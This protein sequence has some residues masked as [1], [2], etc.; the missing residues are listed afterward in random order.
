MRFPRGMGHLISMAD[1]RRDR[2]QS[3]YYFSRGQLVILAFGFT[4]TCSIIFFLGMLVGQGIE[5]RKLQRGGDQKPIP[6]IPL[7]A[8]SQ[9]G[10]AATGPS[11][12]Q[13]M[14]FY[15]TLTRSPA[16][17]QAKAQ[18]ES[19]KDQTKSEPE[20]KAKTSTPPRSGKPPPVKAAEPRATLSTQKGTT[21][22]S[23]QVKAFTRSGDAQVLASKLKGKGY[24]AYVVSSTIKGRTWYR[25]RAG[26]LPTQSEAKSLLERLKARE[27]F[28]QAIITREVP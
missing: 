2:G 3:S 4:V 24:D 8:S 10:G 25:V 28:T 11:S 6:K 13:E 20:K 15:D 17:E 21:V 19:A 23:V 5:E 1:N 18:G 27:N 9:G 14:T 22:W 16:A 12:D 7:L 26:R